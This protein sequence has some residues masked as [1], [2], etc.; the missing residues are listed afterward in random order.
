MAFL[1]RVTKMLGETSQTVVNKTKDIG[2]IAK[3]TA[4]VADLE[5]KMDQIYKTIGKLYVEQYGDDP[6]EAFRHAV[7]SI[8]DKQ[9]KI[10]NYKE[11]IRRLKG[12]NKCA[13]CGAEVESGAQFCSKCGAKVEPVN[14][15]ADVD[16]VFTDAEDAYEESIY[17]E[18]PEVMSGCEVESESETVKEAVAEDEKEE[19]AD[20]IGEKEASTE[21]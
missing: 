6:D 7:A 2:E 20:E 16:A 11:D 4:K 13:G 12:I 14:V 5:R 21:E 1:D 18:E 3:L 15:V 8:K 17:E 19:T 10:I 9:N